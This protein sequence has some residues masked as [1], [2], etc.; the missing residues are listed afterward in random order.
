MTGAPHVR[1]RVFAADDHPIV[2]GG[3]KAIIAADDG[4]ELVGEAEDGVTALQRALHLRPDVAVLDQSMP[5]LDGIEVARQLIASRTGC[6][7][8]M[9][10]VSEDGASIR[11][12]LS[13]GVS[14]YVLKSS[15]TVEL[16]RGVRAV[17]AGGVYLDPAIAAQARV[18][19]APPLRSAAP[20]CELSAREVEV[21]RLAAAG[22]S[23]KI[24]AAR[25]QIGPKSVETYKGRGMTKLGF[26]SRVEVIRYALSQGWLTEA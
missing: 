10:T 6:R 3:V 9:L 22:Y 7:V 12:L 4:L 2:L 24:I 20:C 13:M 26:Q 15:A 17:A 19:D 21:L 14:G 18:T 25:L 23:N 16:A 5:G 1:I 11:H 8:I